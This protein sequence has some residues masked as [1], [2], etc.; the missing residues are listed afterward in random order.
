MLI[1]AEKK[2]LTS[3]L[4]SSLGFAPGSASVAKATFGPLGNG[5][6]EASL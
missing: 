4:T 1:E 3:N 2:K 5:A 6:R